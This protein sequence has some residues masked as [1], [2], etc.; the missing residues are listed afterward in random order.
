[1]II[2]KKTL[3]LT[4]ALALPASHAWAGKIWLEGQPAFLAEATNA[5]STGHPSTDEQ[6]VL[7]EIEVTANKRQSFS[8]KSVQVG[9][10]RDMDPLDVPVTVNSV[11]REVLYAQATNSLFG[12]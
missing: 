11:T 1:M 5:G 10:F 4:L 3:S 8:S 12:S 2:R 7:D 9:T 6:L